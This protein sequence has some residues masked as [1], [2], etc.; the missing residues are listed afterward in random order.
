MLCV[1]RIYD[2]TLTLCCGKS[3]IR[4]SDNNFLPAIRIKNNYKKGIAVFF[5]SHCPMQATSYRIAICC[6]AIAI[7]RSN[8][9]KVKANKILLFSACCLKYLIKD[10]RH[11]QQHD[12][13]VTSTISFRRWLAFDAFRHLCECICEV[14]SMLLPVLLYVPFI[15]KSSL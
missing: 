1:V 3:L 5:S 8:I 4:F 15:F 12:A 2:A 6:H 13:F 7:A 11:R 14:F 9:R 10:N